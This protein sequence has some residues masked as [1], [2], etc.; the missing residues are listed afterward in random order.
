MAP[1]TWRNVD[2]PNFSGVASSLGVA[3]Q[4]LTNATSG[5]SDAID[6]RRLNQTREQSSQAMLGALQY[7]DA[8]KLGEALRTGQ[9][10]GGID[11]RRMT[12]EAIQFLAGRQRD[13]LGND[14]V[15]LNNSGLG[16]RNN[17][18]QFNLDESK[19]TAELQAGYRAA[20]PAANE[21]MAQIRT[22][23]D[24]GDPTQIA[25]GRKLM[26]D[27]SKLFTS[28]G[29]SN[30]AVMGLMSG[31][32]NAANSGM[33]LGKNLASQQDFYEER[34][35]T[36]GEKGLLNSLVQT[37]IDGPDALSKINSMKSLDAQT[38]SNLVKQVTDNAATYFPAPSPMD[39]LP[40]KTQTPTQVLQQAAATSGSN[41][42]S[43]VVSKIINVE[44]GGNSTAK[45]PNSSATGAGQFIDSTWLNMMKKYRPDIQGTQQ[46]LLAMRENSQLSAEMTTRYAQENASTLSSAGI[47]ATESNVYLGHFLG[48]GGAVSLLRASDD[49]PVSK[50]LAPGQINANRSI[51]EGKTVGDV[52]NWAA[53]KMGGA[54]S[55]SPTDIMRDTV[56]TNGGVGTSSNVMSNAD[57]I[58]NNVSSAPQQVQPVQAA[59][60]GNAGTAQVAPTQ[61]VATAAIDKL[62]TRDL[63][64]G[65][66]AIV[67]TDGTLFQKGGNGEYNQVDATGMPIGSSSYK[68]IGMAVSEAPK[69]TTAQAAAALTPTQVMQQAQTVNNTGI[70]DTLS[71]TQDALEQQLVARPY[72]GQD[73]ATVVRTL[74]GGKDSAGPLAN[75]PETAITEAINQIMERANVPADVAAVLAQNATEGKD[76]GGWLGTSFMSGDRFGGPTEGRAGTR[77]D[78]NKAVSLADNFRAVGSNKPGSVA[79]GTAR[80]NT[81]QNQQ[82]A[83]AQVQAIAGQ[84]AQVQDRANRLTAIINSGNATPEQVQMY[85]ATLSQLEMLQMQL[86]LQQ[87]KI[88]PYTANQ[89]AQ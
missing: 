12:P 47:P 28:A 41:S 53:R 51:L 29:M 3:S 37:A 86:Q 38:K 88:A 32:T 85:K 76:L 56:I 79:A 68:P 44:S 35:R 4:L 57:N 15:R 27:S 43:G 21:R 77:I 26:A 67:D 81:T 64:G 49:T 63:P 80:L 69:N 46:Q 19:A 13:L 14:T 83:Q 11:P 70:I 75:V 22:L 20:Q 24:S 66:K 34:Y 39:L 62:P 55:T 8:E 16:I 45:N 30:D 33:E 25:Q 73:T 40:T 1:L 84:V 58:I 17:A 71:N 9:A 48:P 50:I 61:E 60:D 78:V 2:A 87:Q 72:R 18:S 82:Q 54:A 23:F 42:A 5:L 65:G 31:N 89:M 59:V 10:V 7:T 6:K 36:Q 52:K 74:R